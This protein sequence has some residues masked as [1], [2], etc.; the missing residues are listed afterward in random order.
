MGRIGQSDKSG[1]KTQQLDVDEVI[2]LFEHRYICEHRSEGR[3]VRESGFLERRRRQRP[4]EFDRR[5][6]HC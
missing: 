6:F 2:T 5:A 4:V 3:W 1:I